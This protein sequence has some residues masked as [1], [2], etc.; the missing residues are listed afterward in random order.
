MEDHIRI[1]GEQSLLQAKERG[2][3]ETNP[4]NTLLL[5]FQPPEFEKISF[6]YL[7]YPGHGS[8]SQQNNILPNQNTQIDIMD[9]KLKQ[10]EKQHTTVCRMIFY[11][12]SLTLDQTAQRAGK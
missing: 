7:S 6:C 2:L 1:Q 12:K 4:A 11:F 10:E 9:T 5:D 8:L 3:R